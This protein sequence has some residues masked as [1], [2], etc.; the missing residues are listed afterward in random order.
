MSLHWL[1]DF[2]FLNVKP[3]VSLIITLW[4]NIPL[5][6]LWR[7]CVFPADFFQ[8]HLNFLFPFYCDVSRLIFCTDSDGHLWMSFMNLI[9]GMFCQQHFFKYSFCFCFVSPPLGLKFT[10]VRAVSLFSTHFSEETFFSLNSYEQK[11]LDIYRCSFRGL[12]CHISG[13]WW[14][15]KLSCIKINK[16]R[17]EW[18]LTEAG[19]HWA[20][21][22]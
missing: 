13:W 9:F 10:Y 8:E 2:T 19:R 11:A 18:C 12:C 4:S 22:L 7:S 21:L 1:L 15:E 17:E 6:C 5:I 14:C 20:I 16:D 3:L